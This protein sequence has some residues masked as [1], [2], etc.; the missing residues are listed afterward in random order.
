MLTGAMESIAHTPVIDAGAVYAPDY[1]IGP[2]DQLSVR[3]FQVEN[4]SLEEVR[5]DTSG[6][7]EMPLIGSVQ[8][9]GLTPRE[10]SA[11]IERRLGE[12]YLR[13][14]QVSV[15]VIEASSQKVTVDGAVTKPGVYV[16]RGRTTLLQAVAMAEGVTRLADLKEVAVFRTVDGQRMAAKFDL[17][18][19][20]TGQ[21]E[22]PVL[23]GDD[24]ILVNSSNVS[25]V[26][27][28]VLQVLPAFATFFAYSQ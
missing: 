12:R 13:D 7:F 22:D 5:V 17:Q 24:I 6:L 9:A 11:E 25:V 1:K 21:M 28:E 26:L 27:R 2:T 19:V 20:R 23:Q 10:L 4:L 14:P 16:M 3:V 8:A 18:K 15:T